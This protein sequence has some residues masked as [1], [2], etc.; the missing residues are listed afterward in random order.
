[1]KIGIIV[2]VV[3]IV[4]VIGVILFLVVFGI[5]YWLF[6]IEICGSFDFN[7]GILDIEEEVIRNLMYFL[8]I[9]GF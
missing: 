2:F 6:V 8:N 9:V 5:E 3:G 1:M 7:N 4:G